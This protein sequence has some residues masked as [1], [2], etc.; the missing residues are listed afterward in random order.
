MANLGKEIIEA[1]LNYIEFR[2][3][4]DRNFVTELVQNHEMFSTALKGLGRNAKNKFKR[5]LNSLEQVFEALSKTYGFV[6]RLRGIEDPFVKEYHGY[7]RK[8]VGEEGFVK[9]LTGSWDEDIL[10]VVSRAQR[11]FMLPQR[12]KTY[13]EQNP[14]V[15]F[16]PKSQYSS[17]INR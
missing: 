1:K 16:T 15:R 3:G 5:Y 10:S 12:I 14:R 2:W 7:I 4:D 8:R 6:D 9:Y 17:E 13:N 11:E